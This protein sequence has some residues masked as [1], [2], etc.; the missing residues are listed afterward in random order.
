MHI[1]VHLQN[2]YVRRPSMTAPLDQFCTLSSSTQSRCCRQKGASPARSAS[3]FGSNDGL[4]MRLCS[5]SACRPCKR[6]HASALTRVYH[7]R[8]PS[9]LSRPLPAVS[10]RELSALTVTVCSTLLC[11]CTFACV[12]LMFS[13]QLCYVVRTSSS[14]RQGVRACRHNRVL[15]PVTYSQML[16][17][18]RLRKRRQFQTFAPRCVPPPLAGDLVTPT[19][20]QPPSP[21]AKPRRLHSRPDP[22]VR[23]LFFPH[24]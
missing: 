8:P 5:N 16:W 14:F 24:S 4:A 10:R 9:S 17:H 19:C 7:Q 21:R 11:A 1:R 12:S 20:P 15:K 23:T 6:A 18:R 3:A 22:H 2:V 13:T